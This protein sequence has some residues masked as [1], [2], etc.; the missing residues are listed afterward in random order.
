MSG[1]GSAATAPTLSE[2]RCSNL[3]FAIFPIKV[4]HGCVSSW[5]VTLA[6]SPTPGLFNTLIQLK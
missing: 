3:E 4:L 6:N 2:G 5:G 1:V